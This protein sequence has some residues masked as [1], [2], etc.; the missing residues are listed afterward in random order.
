MMSYKNFIYGALGLTI[1]A[2]VTAFNLPD[3]SKKMKEGAPSE[4]RI[5]NR[6]EY[7]QLKEVVVGRWVPNTFRVGK[8]DASLKNFAPYLSD[9]AWEYWAKCE[10]KNIAEV[11]PEDDKNNFLEQENLVKTL[12]NLGVKVRRPDPIPFSS[13]IASQ[14]YSRDPMITIGNKVILANLRS[15]ARRMEV[16]SYGRI[17]QD[18]TEQYQGEVVRMPALK[19]GLAEGNAYLEGGDVFVEGKDIYVGISGNATNDLGI[20]WLR[21]TLGDEYVVHRVALKPNVLHLDCAMMLI[22]D[23]LGVICEEDFED[24]DALPASLKRRKWVTVAPEE[25]QVMATNGIVVNPA[26]I[27]MVDAFPEVAEQIR[28]HGIE[29]IAIPFD[30]ANYYG[31]GLRC[32]YQP[33][34]RE[35]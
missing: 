12:E 24:F 32:S 33:I 26:T 30:K 7:G 29:V 21:E 18:L 6:T 17:A 13:M 22:N 10:D 14:C 27:I 9:K 20:E 35:H 5:S 31:G 11:F 25:A 23:K 2:T 4:L 1:G 34:S 15:E 3:K 19:Q 16:A 28:A 8:V